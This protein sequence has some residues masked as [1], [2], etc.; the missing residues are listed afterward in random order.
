MS[1]SGFLNSFFLQLIYRL[2]LN[3]WT[4]HPSTRDHWSH[5]VVNEREESTWK[6]NRKLLMLKI[7]GRNQQQQRDG[8]GDSIFML[9][10]NFSCIWL[11]LNL[12]DISSQWIIFTSYVVFRQFSLFTCKHGVCK[13]EFSIIFWEVLQ[14]PV[15]Q[16]QLARSWT[17]IQNLLQRTS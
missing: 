7:L 1:F 10:H 5:S 13:I 6:T 9:V 12:L 4:H 2:N 16:L 11:F 14:L 8:E 3:P 17:F 15:R